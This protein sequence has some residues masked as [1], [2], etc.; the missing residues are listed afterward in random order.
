MITKRY[1]KT[2]IKTFYYKD[3][4]LTKE[5]VEKQLNESFSVPAFA[6][7]IGLEY[8]GG[9]VYR[10]AKNICK[11]FCLS[12]ENITKQSSSLNP[13]VQETAW[14]RIIL[15]QNILKKNT[16]TR[17]QELKKRLIKYDI[18]ENK[19]FKCDIPNEWNGR[20]LT[21]HVDHINGCNTDNR[22]GNLRILCPMCHAST[23]T[24]CSKKR[25]DV[26]ARRVEK[27]ILK[28]E[29]FYHDA[30]IKAFEYE[31]KMR[32]RRLNNGC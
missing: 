24:F 26:Y 29:E 6:K 18:W 9:S 15:L 1:I 28:R 20:P 32:N 25:I 13:V 2:D 30:K 14:D 19:C 4:P 12:I 16:K 8:S 27:I 11:Y 22:L 3:T 5:F 21:L 31:E 17:M 7:K 23:Y 10:H